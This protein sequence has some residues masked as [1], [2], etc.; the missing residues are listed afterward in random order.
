M[1][2]AKCYDVEDIKFLVSE[3]KLDN[4]LSNLSAKFNLLTQ[5]LAHEIVL[6][7]YYLL[8]ISFQQGQLFQFF[9]FFYAI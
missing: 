6:T 3:I 7:D 2:N 9:S 8:T 1:S 5:I 4:S